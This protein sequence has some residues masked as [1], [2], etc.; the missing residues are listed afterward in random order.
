M[1][2]SAHTSVSSFSPLKS[3]SIKPAI[4]YLKAEWAKVSNDVEVFNIEEVNLLEIITRVGEGATDINIGF[5]KIS[6]SIIDSGGLLILESELR[7]K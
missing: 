4:D 5:V 3:Y 7:I 6:I 2:S 1:S